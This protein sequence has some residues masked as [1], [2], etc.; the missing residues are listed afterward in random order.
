[1]QN[2]HKCHMSCSRA[3]YMQVILAISNEILRCFDIICI[4]EISESTED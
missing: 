1:M 4:Q 3:V 2:S